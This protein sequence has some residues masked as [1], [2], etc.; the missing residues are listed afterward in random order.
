MGNEFVSHAFDRALTCTTQR[1]LL[2]FNRTTQFR[3]EQRDFSKDVDGQL[4]MENG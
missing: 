4:Q 3:K 1:E 2:N